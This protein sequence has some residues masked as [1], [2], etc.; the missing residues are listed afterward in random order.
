MNP[1][2]VIWSINDVSTQPTSS[3]TPKVDFISATSSVQMSPT[4]IYSLL[5]EL[6]LSPFL[7]VAH[8]ASAAHELW[9]NGWLSTAG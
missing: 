1:P 5:L 3:H 7:S 2:F 8:R 4:Y 9:R 6:S